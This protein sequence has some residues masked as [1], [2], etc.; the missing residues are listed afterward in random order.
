MPEFA[1]ALIVG[2]P[3]GLAITMFSHRLGLL[4]RPGLIKPHARP[5]PY[6][7]G[8]MI[9][10]T[11]LVL[12]PFVGVPFP[13]LLG[14]LLL[15]LVG[16]VDDLLGILLLILLNPAPDKA[17]V[18]LTRVFFT[19]SYTVI[20]I[21]IGYGLT[22]TA[23]FMV[24]QY[25]KFRVWGLAGG[26]A[27]LSFLALAL[28]PTALSV[29]ALVALG[30]VVAFLLLNLPPAR[31]F[32]GDEGSLLLGYLLWLLPLGAVG[33]VPSTRL[34][35]A[36]ALLWLFPLVNAAFVIAS[37]LRAGR[38]LVAGDRSHLYDV[39][40]RRF[41]LRGTLLACWGIA[42]VGAVAAAAIV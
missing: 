31:L 26:A 14:L 5:V 42:A 34:V 1:G 15:W 37:R 8:A 13:A 12:A 41:G 28:M 40:H 21:F 20:S 16:F 9:A 27:A 23:A 17:T 35:L 3:L 29:L 2:V 32:L 7:G 11:V 36:F 39:L 18:E 33:L 4:D 19:S 25:E 24:T 22:L 6:T 38:S 10:L 30:C